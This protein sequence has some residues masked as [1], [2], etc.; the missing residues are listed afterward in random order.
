MTKYTELEIVV[1]SCFDEAFNYTGQPEQEKA[2]NATAFEVAD[3]TKRTQLTNSEAKG[4]IG[5][6]HKKGLLEEW[7]EPEMEGISHIT[8]A[9][10][11]A[12]YAATATK[13]PIKDKPS[14]TPGV[15]D[16]ETRLS[17]QIH[18]QMETSDVTL[19]REKRVRDRGNGEFLG[20]W[21]VDE[22]CAK[23]KTPID[24]D[25]GRPD[26]FAARH[27]AAEA[28]ICMLERAPWKVTK[29]VLEAFGR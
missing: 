14:D 26:Q 28:I 9:G 8:D 22:T 21:F 18:P 19:V 2:D 12:Y 4:V 15:M 27:A 23:W 10:I 16:Y 11:D 20:S 7:G 13:T 17:L 29:E 1:I 6:L 24:R 5:S 25:T 3:V